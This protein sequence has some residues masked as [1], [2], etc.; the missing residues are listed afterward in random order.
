MADAELVIKPEIARQAMN[1]TM[2]ELE[3]NF[4]K[5][6]KDVQ[7]DFERA[8]SKGVNDGARGGIRGMGRQLKRAYSATG[9]T[10]SAV[11]GGLVG[12]AM[13]GFFDTLARAE[14][15]SSLIESL[16]GG[17]N[18][19]VQSMALAK[20]VG[21]DSGQFA[22]ITQN[23]KAGGVASQEDINA[24]IFDINARI[25]EA[26]SGDDPL[27]SNFTKFK[28]EDRVNAV[29][30]SISG[31]SE[32][33]GAKT[34]DQLGFAGDASGILAMLDQAKKRA[35]ANGTTVFD[36]LSTVTESA[37]AEGLSLQTE[38]EKADEFRKAQ[39]AHDADYK[40]KFLD[41]IQTGDIS[42]FFKDRRDKDDAQVTLLTE[43]QDNLKNANDV[44]AGMK[45]TMDELNEV[46][47]S[48]FKAFGEL[49]VFIEKW[50]QED[51]ISK[52]ISQ[53]VDEAT[54]DISKAI[55]NI[56]IF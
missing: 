25:G 15:G 6:A 30:A 53:A 55:S 24:I 13:A 20:Q 49:K 14:G 38:A 43:Y 27:L 9:S 34:L 56:E 51:A 1:Q 17:E 10:R 52:A 32:T 41:E 26:E 2:Q 28:G 42:A 18:Q 37:K 48:G 29:L 5:L 46:T 3:R 4:E 44:Q 47:Q 21:M 7:Q 16:L 36:E 23:L 50:A 54:D 11:G 40:A 45:V 8:I 22:Q 19:A 33:Q 39:M 12:I 35:Q 31:M